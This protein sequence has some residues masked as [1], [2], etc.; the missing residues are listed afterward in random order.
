MEELLTLQADGMKLE[1]AVERKKIKNIYLRVDHSGRITVSAPLR[2]SQKQL[3]DFLCTKRAWISKQLARYSVTRQNTLAPNTA[4]WLGNIKSIRVA[5][6]TENTVRLTEEAFHITMRGT[7]DLTACKTMLE[8]WMRKQAELIFH[9]YLSRIFHSVFSEY[10][11]SMPQL[12]L[13]KMKTLWGSCN[14]TKNKITLN[15]A[16][17]RYSPRYIEY[18]V[19]HELTHLLYIHHD[20]DFYHFLSVHMPDWKERRAE[21]NACYGRAEQD[22]VIVTEEK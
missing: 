21:L 22:F 19:L 2:L 12:S 6:G 16:L 10:S 5:S 8:Q 9:E 18:V 14:P 15:T 1:I 7:V 13:R 4:Y 17:M 20:A 3:T 11:F